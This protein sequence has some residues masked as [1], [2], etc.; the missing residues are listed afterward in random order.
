MADEKKK[1]RNGYYYLGDKA[2]PSVTTILKVLA[3]PALVGWAAKVAATASIENPDW[4]VEQ[5]C[6]EVTGKKESAG[7]RGSVVHGL[8]E[9]IGRGNKPDLS[10]V[11]PEIKPYADGYI[12][13]HNLTIKKILFS[14]CTVVSD[15]HGYAG[16]LDIIALC[17]DNLVWLLDNKTSKGI[18]NE[19]GLQ[20]SSYKHA[21]YIY[22]V[23]E[24]NK[25]AL[26]K[27]DK[28]GAIH[29]KPDGTVGLVEFNDGF[30][31]FLA[32][33]KMYEWMFEED[34]KRVALKIGN[35]KQR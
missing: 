6:A 23:V 18:Y 22:D 17:N 33:K 11:P 19:T 16:T 15:T 32:T 4:S 21:D 26:P 8:I 7:A 25:S 30:E 3:K 14:E 20:L 27:I 31:Y 2:Y 35:Y 10:T 1:R 12:A 5:C 13:F 9:A 34:V 24:G 28:M 29:L